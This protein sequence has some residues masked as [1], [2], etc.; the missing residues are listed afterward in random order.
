MLAAAKIADDE[1]VSDVETDIL[2]IA[3]VN[4]YEDNAKPAVAFI[5][6]FGLKRGAIASTVAHDCHNI[7]AVGVDDENICNAVN[8]LIKH[9][10][11]ISVADGSDIDVMP[12]PVAGLISLDDGQDVA[13]QYMA[14]D[15]KAKGLSTTLQAPFM[16]LSFMAL[17][18]IPNL[19]L[20][21]KGLFDGNS[22]KFTDVQ[23]S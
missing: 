20:S 8:E 1:L 16:T 18:V 17:L 19:K 5:K 10:G 11:G 3:V 15:K 7:I 2:K 23:I 6:N 21:D 13:K 4:R 14:I 9:K 22:F 12:L